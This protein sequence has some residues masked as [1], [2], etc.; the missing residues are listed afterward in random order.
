MGLY[1]QV[2]GSVCSY[3]DFI[4]SGMRDRF[5]MTKKLLSLVLLIA[6]ALS[7]TA[8]VTRVQGATNVV[9][10][11]TTDMT[12]ID[13]MKKGEACSSSI[14]LIFTFGNQLITEAAK[15]GGITNI[16]FVENSFKNYFVF[17]QSCIVV[18]GE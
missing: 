8:C 2:G 10:I 7:V 17:F 13:K 9:S 18:Y 11:E 12:Q 1:S 5:P 15:N 3:S 16:K 4:F 6:F 14:L